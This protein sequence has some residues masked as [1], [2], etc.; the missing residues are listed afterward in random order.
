MLWLRDGPPPR[1]TSGPRVQFAESPKRCPETSPHI[2]AS[3]LELELGAAR[4]AQLIFHFASRR[5]RKAKPP[6]K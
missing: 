2:F 4:E 5:K 1:H 3:G 6:L